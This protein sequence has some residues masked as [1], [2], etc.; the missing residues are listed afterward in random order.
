MSSIVEQAI[1][2]KKRHASITAYFSLY[3]IRVAAAAAASSVA[4]APSIRRLASFKHVKFHLGY[5][6]L[7]YSL[8]SFL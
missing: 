3:R 7:H 6:V 4:R 1:T 2:I 8:L 5:I